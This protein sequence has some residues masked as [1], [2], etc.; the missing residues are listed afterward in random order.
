MLA[1]IQ[2]NL[3]KIKAGEYLIEPGKTTPA[4]LLQNMAAG[5]VLLRQLTIIEGWTFQQIM[6][7]INNNPY[8]Q[9]NFN[10]LK[11]DEIMAQLGYP[12]IN[13]EGR[14]YPDTYLFSKGTADSKILKKSYQKMQILLAQQWNSRAANLPYQNQEEALTAASLIERETAVPQ[15]RPMVAGVIVRRLEKNM[16]LQIDPTVI[17]ALGN[18]YK[19]KLSSQDLKINSP[20]NTYLYKGLPPTPIA[21]PSASSLYAALHPASG[22]A[23]FYVANGR[24]SHIFSAT[25]KDH[26]VAIDK[27]LLAPRICVSLPLVLTTASLLKPAAISTQKI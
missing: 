2:G 1:R 14:F 13:P 12:N 15:E 11:N 21:V 23:L 4:K 8:L 22:D 3:G 20:Y 17:Y 5:R 16:R 7:A 10:T 6:N 26:D 25:L 27:Y 24:G 9:H 19:G 18:A